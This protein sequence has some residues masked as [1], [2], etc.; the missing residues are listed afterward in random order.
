MF[1]CFKAKIPLPFSLKMKDSLDV[2]KMKIGKK[3]DYTNKNFATKIW[4]LQRNDNK[5]YFVYADFNDD[6]TELC[7]ITI[8]TYDNTI[9]DLDSEFVIKSQ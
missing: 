9:D 4:Y 1:L 2:V 5:D 7:G 3:E 8:Q 6:Y